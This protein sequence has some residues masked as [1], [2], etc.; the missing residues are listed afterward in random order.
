MAVSRDLPDL[1]TAKEFQSAQNTEL[2]D[3]SGRRMGL[4]TSQTVRTVVDWNQISPRMM[5][6]VVAMEDE[7]FWDNDHGV[8]LRGIARAFVQDVIQG[9]S[10]QGGSTIPQQLVKL[11]LEKEDER[12]VLQKLRE[13]GLAF[14]MS[15]QWS[16]RK[17][18]TSYL[19]RVYFGNGA[20][21]VESAAK[22]YFGRSPDH[23][24]CAPP[25]NP[26]AKSLTISE[27]ALLA[28]I[29]ASPSGFDPAQHP[30]AALN[31]RDI[32]LRK[33]L[34]QGRIKQ[35]EYDTA[36]AEPLPTTDEIEPPGLNVRNPYFASWV[37]AQLVERYGARRTYEGG[38]TV[39][40]TLDQSIQ[41]AAEKAVGTYLGRADGP[42]ASLVAIDNRTG[43]VRAMVGGSN[44]RTKPFNLATQSARQPGSAFKPFVLAQAL[45]QGTSINQAYAS[46]KRTFRVKDEGG[47]TETF[48]VTNDHNA[49]SGTT[50][51]GRALTWSDNTVFAQVGIDTGVKKIA[52]LIR[53]MGI[54]SPVSHNAALV[55]GAPRQGV[56][57]LDM[58]HA[59]E[60]FATRGLRI[61][62]SLGAPNGGPVGILRVEDGD[63][64]LGRNKVRRVRVVSPEVADITTNAMRTVVSTGT[65]KRAD[66]G[67]FAAGKTGTSEYNADAWFVG[68]SKRLTVAGWVGYPDSGK[69]ME[70]EYQGGPV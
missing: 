30:E 54:R 44:Y 18:L 33:M 60:T 57:P 62:G 22:T 52:T 67:G 34:Q 1:E 24:G 65:G 69:P 4:L 61:N 50:T 11:A 46:K 32:V 5:D 43:E 51:L 3:R 68:F 20:Y 28:A 40:T 63:K 8:D 42:Q 26:C 29:I 59:Y 41:N 14:H 39:K 6:A 36:I 47:R 56:T 2:L 16:K 17:I 23:E 27:S 21:G 7:R 66:Y 13:I 48:T 10:A 37:S 19:N 9:H 58:A 38:L 49:Y 12:T 55:L 45:R 70:T 25:R 15:K 53:R 31:R 64:T 35:D